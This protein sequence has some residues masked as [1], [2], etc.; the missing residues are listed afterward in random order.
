MY[1]HIPQL[2]WFIAYAFFQIWESQLIDRNNTRSH[3]E[4]Q[5]K[6]NHNGKIADKCKQKLS[7]CH[8]RLVKDHGGRL[9]KQPRLLLIDK[10]LE[11]SVGMK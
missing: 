6:S 4:N 10:C 1:T 3:R 2:D 11:T 5:N 8:I 7:L 9:V